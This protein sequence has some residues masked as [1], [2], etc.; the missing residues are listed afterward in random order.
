MSKAIERMGSRR[1]VSNPRPH[2]NPRTPKQE[3]LLP[4]FSRL[5]TAISASRFIVIRRLA[6][7]SRLIRARAG[8]KRKV[9]RVPC[10][11]GDLNALNRPEVVIRYQ[12][13]PAAASCRGSL[14]SFTLLFLATKSSEKERKECSLYKRERE[15]EGGGKIA[16]K[17][18]HR[19]DSC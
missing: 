13:L 7:L 17:R 19:K 8:V 18:D 12:L 4:N 16:G 10:Q 15:G 9:I 2:P 5:S 1:K 3:A 6:R 11:I 14:V